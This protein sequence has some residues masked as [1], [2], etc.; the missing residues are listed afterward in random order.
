M[1]LQG[2]CKTLYQAFC[3][4]ATDCIHCPVNLIMKALHNEIH[5][6]MNT[7]CCPQ[8]PQVLGRDPVYIKSFRAVL[9]SRGQYSGR[10]RS[11]STYM[12][13]DNFW[14]TWNPGPKTWNPGL[15]TLNVKPS[16]L[17]LW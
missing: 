13:M 3:H 10:L 1:V 4:M 11:S 5:R 8:N 2:F 12:C 6:T 14:K 17:I 9:N 16:Q 7:V 15:K